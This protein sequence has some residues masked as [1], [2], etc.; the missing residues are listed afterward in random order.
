MLE[1]IIFLIAL[2]TLYKAIVTQTVWWVFL[3]MI[4]VIIWVYM[5]IGNVTWIFETNNL[6][7]Q[8]NINY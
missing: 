2:F 3:F 6:L 5:F 1:W 7:R 4:C 8:E